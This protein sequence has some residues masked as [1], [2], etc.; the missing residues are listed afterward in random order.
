MLNKNKKG[1]FKTIPLHNSY[2]ILLKVVN[3]LLL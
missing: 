1:Y 3:V 2:L